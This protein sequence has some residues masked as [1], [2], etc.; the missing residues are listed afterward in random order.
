MRIKII[1]LLLS[2][3]FPVCGQKGLMIKQGD[4]LVFV[5]GVGDTLRINKCNIQ[6][7]GASTW[8]S[9]TGTLNNQTDLQNELNAKQ[10][11]I[12]VLPFANGGISGAQAAPATT[13]TMTINMTA[14]VITITPTGAVTFN[15]SGGV[16][17]QRVT[18]A[19]TTS[20][21]TSFTITFGTNFRKVGTLATGT[22]SARF[23]S[24]TFVCIN[25]IIW[26]EISRTAVQ[27]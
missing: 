2:F 27:T 8:G 26:Q 21:T 12:T 19:V 4:T 3:Y 23:F 13:G 22:V 16:A 20:G 14:S 6:G 24:V 1:I 17:G 25:G 7:G 18:F 11:T 5:R 15:A 10:N 9:I